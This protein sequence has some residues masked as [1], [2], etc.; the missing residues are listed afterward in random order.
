[1]EDLG[2]V[3]KDSQN[4]FKSRLVRLP[5]ARLDRLS[6]G[7]RSSNTQMY[8]VQWISDFKL[9]RRGRHCH[10]LLDASGIV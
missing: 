10:A 7:T 4:V 2:P 3:I 5:Y 8:D 9:R 6:V 1:V